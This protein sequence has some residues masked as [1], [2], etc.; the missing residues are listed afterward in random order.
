MCCQSVERPI[1]SAKA[2]GMPKRVIETEG[3]ADAAALRARRWL[4]ESRQWAR[5]ARESGRAGGRAA[6]DGSAS[7]TSTRLVTKELPQLPP[8]GAPLPVPPQD[9]MRSQEW[10]RWRRRGSGF[11]S[12]P[13]NGADP[14]WFLGSSAIAL[15]ILP[16]RTGTTMTDA[17]S[18]ENA[19]AA[20]SFGSLFLT[21]QGP[22]SRTA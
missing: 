18:I 1:A 4:Q 5:C 9:R 21:I 8:M 10:R 16:E 14:A 2:S 12:W 17:G 13:E 20:I 22:T 3:K 7:R 6:G 11:A 15:A 19:Q